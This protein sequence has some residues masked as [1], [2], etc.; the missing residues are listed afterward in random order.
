MICCYN[1]EKYIRETIDS[2]IAQT[3]H[4]WEMVIINDGSTDDTENIVLDYK[5]K[6][7]PIIYFK[8]NNLGFA[9]ARNKAISIAN[10]ENKQLKGIVNTLRENLEKTQIDIDERIQ[11]S[12]SSVNDVNKQLKDTV[13]TLRGRIESK[14]AQRIEELQA[15][16][17]IKRDEHRQLEAIINTLREKLEVKDEDKN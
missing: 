13:S 12:V 17:K 6:G 16:A 2:V 9:A 1:S 3:H 10:D 8:Q 11:K 7:V 15:A 5:S 14:E 4:S